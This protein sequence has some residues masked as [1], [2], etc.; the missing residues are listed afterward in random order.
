[1]N[2]TRVGGEWGGVYPTYGLRGC[3]FEHR[4]ARSLLPLRHSTVSR[5]DAIAN[6]DLIDDFATG[7]TSPGA[8]AFGPAVAGPNREV[9][10]V[11]EPMA[12]GTSH[13]CSTIITHVRSLFRRLV[14]DGSPHCNVARIVLLLRIAKRM[15]AGYRSML[16]SAPDVRKRF[17]RDAREADWVGIDRVRAPETSS[18]AGRRTGRLR[19]LPS[20][21]HRV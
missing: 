13:L 19:E 4:L 6:D 1:M 21:D 3:G 17:M 14:I 16:M 20:A 7:D 18:A 5:A 8:T 15:W 10:G 9:Y 11:H 12:A 2:E